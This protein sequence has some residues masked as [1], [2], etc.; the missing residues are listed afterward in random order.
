MKRNN[1]I[2]L[3]FV[4][5]FITA[6]IIFFKYDTGKKEKLLRQLAEEF[7][8]ISIDQR[9]EGTV[10]HIYHPYP[11][12]FNNDPLQV[13]LLLNDSLK[14]RIK[15]GHELDKSII[16]DSVLNIS[17]YL[18]K[19][20]GSDVLFVYK[21]VGSDTIRYSFQLRDDLGYPLRKR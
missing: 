18:F 8:A 16:L 1:I 19:E 3:I 7:P 13:Y 6:F 4:F 11:E 9:L 14:R 12:V 20:P 2:S 5:V 10:M 21:V 17:D 15:T